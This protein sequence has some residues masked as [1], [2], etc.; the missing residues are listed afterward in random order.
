MW[1]A[2]LPSPEPDVGE[3]IVE[4]TRNGA[5]LKCS[6][7]H[8]ATGVEASAIGPATE[9]AGLERIAIAKLRRALAAR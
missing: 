9:R 7:V 1:R 2:S 6:A 3:V 5:Y 8:V 4:L